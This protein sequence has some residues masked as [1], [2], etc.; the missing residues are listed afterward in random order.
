MKTK[1]SR[2]SGWPI[3]A[4]LWRF[5]SSIILKSTSRLQRLQ[6]AGAF[7]DRVRWVE[8]VLWKRIQPFE[9]DH[10]FQVVQATLT[11]FGQF[12]NPPA[13]HLDQICLKLG[14]SYPSLHRYFSEM[15]GYSPK[16]C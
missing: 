3:P 11:R 16:Y 13:V 8:S 14:V 10:R 2:I 12:S 9:P 5:L 1:R 6:A 7:R 4:R 15:L